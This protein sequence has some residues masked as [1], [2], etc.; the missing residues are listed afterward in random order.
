MGV[1]V[2]SSYIKVKH[3]ACARAPFFLQM[4]CLRAFE[5]LEGWD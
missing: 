4:S 2:V 1:G 3:T 5:Y